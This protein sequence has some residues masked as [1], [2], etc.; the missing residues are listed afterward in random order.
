[1]PAS[2]RSGSLPPVSR[3]AQVTT[4]IALIA[5]L[6]AG[7]FAVRTPARGYTV[8]TVE[9][10]EAGFN[11][12][13]CRMNREYVRF[14][15]VGSR[16]LRVIR[17]GVVTGDPPLL[18]TGYIKPGEYSNEIIIPHGGTTEF[19]DADNLS[20]SMTVVTPVYVQYWEPICTPDSNYSPP[21]PP[22]R[23]NPYCLR[24]PVAA[25]D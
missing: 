13:V 14:K 11:P 16:P 9:V 18:D 23:S 5:I 1:M 21:Q 15:N 8:Q 17:P 22:C 2:G 6:A 3:T 12:G 7:L 10:S 20:H 4:A 24:L 19:F 25:R